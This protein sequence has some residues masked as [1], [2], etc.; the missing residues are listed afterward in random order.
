M[1]LADRNG[2]ESLNALAASPRW[3]RAT[4]RNRRAD[5]TGCHLR[6]ITRVRQVLEGQTQQCK[7]GC[8]TRAR[9]ALPGHT[10][11]TG[12]HVTNFVQQLA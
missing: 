11:H 9:D 8:L 2:N 5:E 6:H 7:C 10:K 4:S 12:R 3:Q 1:F